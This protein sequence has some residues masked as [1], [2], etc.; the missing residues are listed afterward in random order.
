MH[1]LLKTQIGFGPLRHSTITN[2][3][4]VDLSEVQKNVLCHGLDFGVPRKSSHEEVKAE[5]EICWQQLKERPAVSDERREEC[6]L[7][8]T[9]L[10]HK[11]ANSRLD[12]T[13]FPLN[14]EHLAAPK[15]LRNNPDIIITRP[16]KGSG[17]VFLDRS[18]YVSKMMF[19]LSQENKF[20]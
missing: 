11:Y 17:V 8:L 20:E 4:S 6:K 12:R 9:S 13:G 19:I 15:E 1:W 2:L 16:D 14:K 10:A 7:T 18:E 3:S 5:F